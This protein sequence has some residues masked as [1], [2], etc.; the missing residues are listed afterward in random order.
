MPT[1]LIMNTLTCVTLTV[2]MLLTKYSAIK[3]QVE[4]NFKD[5][6]TQH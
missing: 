2:C 5:Q 6:N 1:Q 3:T 4:S